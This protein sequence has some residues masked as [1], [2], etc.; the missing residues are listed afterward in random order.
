MRYWCTPWT[1]NKGRDERAVANFTKTAP[2]NMHQQSLAR[3]RRRLC[4]P[5]LPSAHAL[6][7]LPAEW[8][9]PDLPRIATRIRAFVIS[10][11]QVRKKSP[12]NTGHKERIFS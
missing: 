7:H 6:H 9:R 11:D 3:I 5:G 1:E 12:V 10:Q 2:L 4:W 8:C